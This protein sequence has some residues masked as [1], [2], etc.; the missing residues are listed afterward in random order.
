MERGDRRRQRSDDRQVVG[1][2]E[3]FETFYR[4]EVRGVLAVTIGLTRRT[5][6]AEDATQEAF[7][8]AWRDWDRIGRLERPAAWVR[9]VALNLAI[10]R[11]RQVRAETRA[12]LRLR[13]NDVSPPADPVSD[14]FWA[15]VR[16]LPRRQAQVVALTYVDDLD[17]DGVAA[18]LGISASTVRV[19]LARA[20]VALAERLEVEE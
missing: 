10:G 11:W 6:D 7:F 20:R 9:R 4:R 5:G 16:A 19:H 8:R 14:R 17:S 1:S 3:P 13:P 15:E 12:V 2:P 18:V